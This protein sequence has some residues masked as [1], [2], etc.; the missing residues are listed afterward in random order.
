M[1]VWTKFQFDK[2]QNEVKTKTRG[3]HQA[4]QIFSMDFQITKKE[5]V[6]EKLHSGL[7]WSREPGEINVQAQGN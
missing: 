6:R 1:C 3:M 2:F 5:P 7:M 4:I